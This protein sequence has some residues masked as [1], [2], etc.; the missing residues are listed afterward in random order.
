MDPIDIPN[1]LR[2]MWMVDAVGIPVRFRFRLVGTAITSFTGRDN[3]GKWVDEVYDDF[4]NTGACR[5][6]NLCLTTGVPLCQRGNVI[7]NPEYGD[8]EAERIYLPLASNGSTVDIIVIMTVYLG[9]RPILGIMTSS[10]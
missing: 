3:T 2:N 6:M 5:R 10:L 9:D 4:A 8:L 7:S 1:L